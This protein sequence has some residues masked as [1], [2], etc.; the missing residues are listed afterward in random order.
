MKPIVFLISFLFFF[1]VFLVVCLPTALL[2][3]VCPIN[4]DHSISY[5]P[6][7]ISWS[8]STFFDELIVEFYNNT[9]SN[10]TSIQNFT[11][12]SLNLKNSTSTYI[13]YYIES[14]PVSKISVCYGNRNKLYL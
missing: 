8:K 5:N 1:T 14:Y 12:T 9:S 11:S 2:L 13:I 4:N 7:Y 10:Y 6:P 3:F